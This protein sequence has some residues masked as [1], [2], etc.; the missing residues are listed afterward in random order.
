MQ[1]EVSQ[2]TRPR[3]RGRL[4]LVLL[5]AATIP[6]AAM[7]YHYPPSQYHFYP[8]CLFHKL[9]GMHCPGCGATRAVGAL[10]KGD[11]LQAL[12]YNVLF[13]L[14]LPVILVAGYRQAR[15]LWTGE[16][17]RGWRLS[18][19]MLYVVMALIISYWVL[20][21]IPVFPFT[22]LAPHALG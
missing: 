16:P 15:Q 2:P 17:A 6:V 14:F 11:L 8:P 7:V 18:S 5:A 21:N 20:R 9:T 12:A 10:V 19:R 3:W 4:V 13:I 22:L 1:G